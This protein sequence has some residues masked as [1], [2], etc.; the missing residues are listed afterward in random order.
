MHAHVMA[1]IFSN[2]TE[3]LS[4]VHKPVVASNET[5][6]GMGEAT[7]H[8]Y[9]TDVPSEPGPQANVR[10]PQGKPQ[11]VERRYAY[12]ACATVGA[13]TPP[14]LRV[15]SLTDVPSG[16]A[17]AAPNAP[18]ASALTTLDVTTPVN[19][20]RVALTSV[21]A[22][23]RPLAKRAVTVLVGDVGHVTLRTG[24]TNAPPVLMRKTPPSLALPLL[25]K[26]PSP[27][28]LAHDTMERSRMGMVTRY[29][30]AEGGMGMAAPP[31]TGVKLTDTTRESRGRLGSRSFV[32][33]GRGFAVRSVEPVALAAVCPPTDAIADS[34][35]LRVEDKSPSA[36]P[37]P[38]EDVA[39]PLSLRGTSGVYTASAKPTRS[40]RGE[41]PYCVS[42][43]MYD[44]PW[45]ER[46]PPGAESAARRRGG[47]V[48]EGAG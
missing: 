20:V 24:L 7:G 13:P 45:A 43:T 1:V 40:G 8:A 3:H 41:T 47:R 48:M 39:S 26:S 28:S 6:E 12:E 35:E 23:G 38:E 17:I 4:V 33:V 9:M 34:S 15:L 44:V 22:A 18:P 19:D 27:S 31:P 42:A 36:L 11:S 25:R 29:D 37:P 14:P 32:N 5:H 46:A 16:A 30:C 10:T 21:T 2:A